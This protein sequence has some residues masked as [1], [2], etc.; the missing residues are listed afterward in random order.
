MEKGWLTLSQGL[1]SHHGVSNGRVLLCFCTKDRNE[2]GI[3]NA[4]KKWIHII[5]NKHRGFLS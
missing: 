3:K 1:Y 5:F 4:T 2:R